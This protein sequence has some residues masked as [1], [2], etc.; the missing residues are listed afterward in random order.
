MTR[1]SRRRSTTVSQIYTRYTNSSAWS[2]ALGIRANHKKL[3][4][5]IVDIWRLEG[6]RNIKRQYFAYVPEK[7]KD[8]KV[9]PNGAPV[10]Y[11]FGG[12][13]NNDFNYFEASQYVELADTYGFSFVMPGEHTSDKRRD[14][15]VEHQRE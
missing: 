1:E 15:N 11:A 2:N 14:H 10:I 3:G 13:G 8:K 12:N 6:G 7:V 9:Y 5:E 4:V